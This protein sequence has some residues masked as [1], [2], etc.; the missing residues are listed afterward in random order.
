MTKIFAENGSKNAL[1]L[2]FYQQL[3]L[4][5]SVYQLLEEYVLLL[6]RE[7]HQTNTSPAH[8]LDT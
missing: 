1:F 5:Q 8:K 6:P 2:R 4:Q 3:L 7:I